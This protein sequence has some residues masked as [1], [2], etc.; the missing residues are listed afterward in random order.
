MEDSIQE[1]VRNIQHLSGGEMQCQYSENLL[2]SVLKENY[3]QMN[4]KVYPCYL[5]CSASLS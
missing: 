1:L 2:R 5:T 3:Q 4:P